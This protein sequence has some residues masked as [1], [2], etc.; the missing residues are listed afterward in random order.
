MGDARFVHI[1]NLIQRGKDHLS[2]Q[3]WDDLIK[4]INLIKDIKQNTATKSAFYYDTE[5]NR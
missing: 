3:E 4:E 2:I 5:R 1:K